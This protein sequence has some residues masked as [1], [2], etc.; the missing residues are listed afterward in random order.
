[1]NC[2]KDVEGEETRIEDNQEENSESASL[3]FVASLCVEPGGQ[4]END[5]H[6]AQSHREQG[7]EEGKHS[8]SPVVPAT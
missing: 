1:M 7:Q 8:Q 5:E 3:L 2:L 4:D 6:I